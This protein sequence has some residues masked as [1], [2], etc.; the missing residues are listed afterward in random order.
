MIMLIE[1]DMCRVRKHIM[2][3]I[4]C[5]K[6]YLDEVTALYHRTVAHLEK[7]INYP[8][9]SSAHP[10]DDGI[11]TAIAAG[12]QYICVE[13]GKTLGAVVLNENPEG[14]YEAGD[15]SRD[16]KPGEFLVVHAL[17]V[18]P[19]VA[20]KGVGRF[21]VEQCVKMARKGGCKALRLDVVP[22]NVPARRLYEKMGFEYV[23]TRDLRRNIDEIPVFDLF[24]LNLDQPFR[25]YLSGP[26]ENSPG[27]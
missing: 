19:L 17:A 26:L 18:D 14:C 9:W 12:E 2:E 21:M 7:H 22:G 23:G 1:I 10:S 16:L 5:N 20:R 11:S 13:N 3:L 6:A 4:K 27:F 15:W 24:E 8:K 25:R